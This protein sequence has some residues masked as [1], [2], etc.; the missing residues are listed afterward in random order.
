MADIFLSGEGQ[1]DG[2]RISMVDKDKT[3]YVIQ[4]DGDKLRIRKLTDGPMKG[5]EITIIPVSSNV[6]ILK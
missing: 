2:V 4:V 3:M 5:G 6:I 1:P